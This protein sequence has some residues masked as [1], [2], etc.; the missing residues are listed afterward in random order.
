MLYFAAARNCK[1]NYLR[2]VTPSSPK[3]SPTPLHVISCC[4][5]RRFK[6]A[7]SR[8]GS[9]RVK[10]ESKFEYKKDKAKYFC[11]RRDGFKFYD[12]SYLVGSDRVKFESN[13][14]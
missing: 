1:Q 4:A 5:V 7:F 9:R 14:V 8:C 12:G 10:F 13:E 11:S 3:P 2:S 6:F